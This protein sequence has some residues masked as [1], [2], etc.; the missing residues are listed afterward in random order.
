MMFNHR[1]VTRFRHKHINV[2]KMTI[3]L[4]VLKKCFFTLQKC[5]F[6]IYD[7]NFVVISEFQKLFIHDSVMISLRNICIFLI[8]HDIIIVLM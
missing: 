7:D 3:V 2:K 5:H 8:K 4:F 6:I 1:F